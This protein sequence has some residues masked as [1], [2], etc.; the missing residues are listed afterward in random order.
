[1]EKKDKKRKT[2]RESMSFWRGLGMEINMSTTV[3]VSG[4]LSV[5][6]IEWLLAAKWELG[7]AEFNRCMVNWRSGKDSTGA[8]ILIIAAMKHFDKNNGACLGL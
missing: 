2:G 8:A 7:K 1:M 4:E 6:D 5:S 3:N